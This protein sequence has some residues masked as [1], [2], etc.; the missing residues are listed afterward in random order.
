MTAHDGDKVARVMSYKI[1]IDR[2][3]KTQIPI[4]DVRS[5]MFHS[6]R[7]PQCQRTMTGDYDDFVMM[8]R[9]ARRGPLRGLTRLFSANATIPIKEPKLRDVNALLPGRGRPLTAGF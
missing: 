6:E 3:L 9:G 4:A 8:K 1:A 5:L 2:L 7:N